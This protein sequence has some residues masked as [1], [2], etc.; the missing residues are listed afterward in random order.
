MIGLSQTP[1]FFSLSYHFAFNLTD[2]L[3]ELILQTILYSV[4]YNVIIVHGNRNH[5]S[6]K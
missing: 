1:F 3:N 2:S 6:Q 5:N 4:K